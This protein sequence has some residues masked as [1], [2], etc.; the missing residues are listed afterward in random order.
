MKS[1]LLNSY[2]WFFSQIQELLPQ[3]RN[4]LA[5]GVLA[6]ALS[7]LI[8]GLVKA[9]GEMSSERSMVKDLQIVLRARRFGIPSIPPERLGPDLLR[10]GGIVTMEQYPILKYIARKSPAGARMKHS[11]L[12]ISQTDELEQEQADDR[13]VLPT[14]YFS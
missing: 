2:M 11:A 4:S 8:H 1:I 3:D 5:V 13:S 10:L 9:P 6:S 14:V 7:Y 12:Q